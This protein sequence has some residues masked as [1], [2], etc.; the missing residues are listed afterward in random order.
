MQ[1]DTIKTK[2]C[3][4]QYVDNQSD[5]V[6]LKDVTTETDFE[7]IAM[8]SKDGVGQLNVFV[9]SVKFC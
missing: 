6:N 1:T 3:K 2:L 7:M 9:N 4:D 5:L 8:K